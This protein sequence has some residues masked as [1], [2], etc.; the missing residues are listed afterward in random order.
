MGLLTYPTI[1]MI[2]YKLPCCDVAVGDE[3]HVVRTGGGM[4]TL[5]TFLC[6]RAES[7][8]L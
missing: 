7:F 6:H 8:I 3:E 1:S 5:G 2:T 4:E